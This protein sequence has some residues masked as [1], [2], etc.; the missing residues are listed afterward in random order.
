MPKPNQGE[1]KKDFVDRC[2]PIVLQEGTAKDGA[3]AAAICHSMYEE[4]KKNLKLET[5]DID[6]PVE[7]AEI[8]TWKGHTFTEKD[9]DEAIQNFNNKIASPYITID[10]D[11]KTT[12]KWTKDVDAV[13]L[14][15]ISELWREGKKLMA[16]F[17][18]V[19]KLIAELIDAGSLKQR[20]IE[21]WKKFLHASGKTYNNVLE[22]VTFFGA[23]GLPA[24]SGLA[25]V[26]KLFKVDAG[27]YEFNK[28]SIEQHEGDKIIIPFKNQEE[29]MADI[30]LTKEEYQSLLENKVQLEKFKLDVD[31][32]DKE[33][34]MLKTD[35]STVKT[36]NEK[37]KKEHDDILK[38]KA[39]IEKDKAES[40]K[41]EAEG[42]ID[43][44]IEKDRKLLPKFRDFK[45]NEYLAFKKADD[46]DGLKL[47]KE[48][49]ESR[50]KVILKTITTG[51]DGNKVEYKA[52]EVDNTDPELYN[53]LDEK[54]Q[55]QMKLKGYDNTP[56]NYT[57][58]GIELG[59]FNSSDASK[60]VH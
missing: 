47:F 14:G 16:K 20:S 53:D 4:N 11:T 51:K 30:E 19:P 49:L 33:I 12:A 3:Q 15:N 22:A 32:K 2:I 25:D 37:L 58:A 38:L 28:K 41:K 39:D 35:L 17:K 44:L 42:Y 34:A 6:K 52:D 23:N 10:H 7:I 13:S 29:K 54:V 26:P 50:E 21:Y 5:V 18:Q 60:E 55:A 24:I 36:D 27:M 43:N 45:I 1:S 40:L 31:G 59:I 46:E 57:K 48:D 9:F 8:G 56:E